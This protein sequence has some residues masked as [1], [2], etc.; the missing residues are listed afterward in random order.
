MNG[1]EPGDYSA[2]RAVMVTGMRENVHDERVLAAFS[3]VPRERFVPA[4]H[5]SHA[6]D[7]APLPIGY[8]QTISQPLVVG[9]MLEALELRASDRVL[10]IGTGSGYQAALLAELA[11]SVVSVERIPEL[12]ARAA[13][14]L[15]ELGY[16]NVTVEA[17][18]ESLG[19][20]EAGPY[21]AI[22][23]AAA[24]P[25]VPQVL[26]DQLG[27]GGRLVLP[28]GERGRPQ[29]LLLIE[30]TDT[31]VRTT[32]RGPCGFVPLIGGGAFP[33]ED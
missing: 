18:S 17:A 31:G 3:R 33:A 28:V 4:A 16:R 22:A 27:P 19:W 7:N 26:I 25:D 5:R 12:L 20:P 30:K 10:D 6:Y 15:D 2:W 11:E 8:G 24:A 9:L 32:S 14:V 1:N 23:V 29:E 13:A 21:N